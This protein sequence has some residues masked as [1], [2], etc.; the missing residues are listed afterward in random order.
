MLKK[1]GDMGSIMTEIL[2][3]HIIAVV[4]CSRESGKPSHDVPEYLQEVGYKIIPVNPFA[5]YILGEKVY[6]KL[7]DIPIKIDVVDVFRPSAEALEI[8]EE[9][10]AIGAKAVWLQEGIFNE[11]AQK[12]AEEHNMLFVMNRCMIKEHYKIEG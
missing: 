5:D 11:D 2:K 3:F 6:K 8:T 7:S 4:G 10:Y 9:A 12:F 1:I